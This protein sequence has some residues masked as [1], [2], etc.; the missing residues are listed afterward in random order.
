[1]LFIVSYNV[2]NKPCIGYVFA[3]MYLSVDRKTHSLFLHGRKPSLHCPGPL[4][5]TDPQN[6]APRSVLTLLMDT[7]RH[8]DRQTDR[9]TD[10]KRRIIGVCCVKSSG[11]G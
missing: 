7:N 6:F 10:N 9:P 5:Y 8:T 4:A 2:F 1:L 3:F 11:I